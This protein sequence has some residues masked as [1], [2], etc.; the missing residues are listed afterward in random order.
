MMFYVD[1]ELS[2]SLGVQLRG[3]IE[4][5]IA[6]GELAAGERLPSVRELADQ[7]GIA[8]MTV[9]QVYRELKE[10]GL[11]ETR[12]G[13]G[14][15]VADSSKARTGAAVDATSLYRRV[16][17]LIEDGLALGLKPSEL[18]ALFTSRVFHRAKSRR[19][20]RV[21]MIG[22][23][24][25]AT[26]SYSRFIAE[27]LKGL[28]TV[29]PATI[30]SIRGDSE[31]RDDI[32]SADLVITFANRHRE[33]EALLPN[34]PVVAI[35]FIPSEET[36]MALASLSPL[37]SV[38]VVSRFPEFLPIM[39]T[40]VQRF[41]P[42]VARIAATALEA[43]DL[44]ETVAEAGVVIYSSGAESVLERLAPEATAIEYRHI[45]DPSEIE[46]VVIPVLREREPAE[47]SLEK[48]AS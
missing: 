11:I 31:L 38:A 29:E 24:Q 18:A 16:D 30:E 42:H 12:A 2:V 3:L 43:P 7:V 44:D 41:A 21:V 8:P 39:K 35:S 13:S 32:A 48:E 46:R 37:A 45:P 17:R 33:V 6:Y 20:A 25:H 10:A 34:T 19:R 40:G 1:R 23:F 27:R 14:T 28:A 15:F 26:V 36:R 22:L 4:Y 5:G 9:S 47:L